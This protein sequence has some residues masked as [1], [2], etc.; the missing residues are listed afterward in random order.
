MM[1]AIKAAQNENEVILLEKMSTLRK[2]IA[3]NR[4]R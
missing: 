3:Y 1:A 2:E 4:K